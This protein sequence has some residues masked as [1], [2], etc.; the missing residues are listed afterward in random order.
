MLEKVPSVPLMLDMLPDLT[1][2]ELQSCFNS[3]R[4]QG[5]TKKIST[6][7]GE[8]FPKKLLSNRKE[9]STIEVA[10]ILTVS[11]WNCKP[12]YGNKK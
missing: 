2:N 6:L 1:E 7:L 9:W 11:C 3:W 4:N 12:Q 5:G 8:F 10:I